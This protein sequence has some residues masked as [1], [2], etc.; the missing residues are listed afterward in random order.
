[1]KSLLSQLLKV[2]IFLVPE[3]TEESRII[4]KKALLHPQKLFMKNI[5]KECWI[6]NVKMDISIYTVVLLET[7]SIRNL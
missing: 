6:R 3:A 7:F 5:S 1:M 4:P 2:L